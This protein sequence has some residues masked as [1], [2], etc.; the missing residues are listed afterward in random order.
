MELIVRGVGRVSLVMGM[1]PE[2]LTTH[3]A[4]GHLRVQ[5]RAW[6]QPSILTF[7][8]TFHCDVIV[9][10]FPK[11]RKCE[12]HPFHSPHSFH[13]TTFAEPISDLLLS[14]FMD[15]ING[16]EWG[17]GPYKNMATQWTKSFESVCG[18]CEH[19]FDCPCYYYHHRRGV[20]VGIVVGEKERD[21]WWWSKTEVGCWSQYLKESL[22]LPYSHLLFFLPALDPF[23]HS[24]H[25]SSLSLASLC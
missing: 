15:W 6:K 21:T 4:I 8:L 7:I 16:W 20:S 5:T 1:F 19:H 18:D 14:L 3:K 11:E 23:L 24:F 2:C 17:K 10:L 22:V 13:S 9:C 12:F 25:T